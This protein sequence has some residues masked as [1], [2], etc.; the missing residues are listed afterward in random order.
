VSGF[1][2]APRDLA[3]MRAEGALSASA[4]ELLHFIAESGADRPQGLQTSVGYLIDALGFSD[5]TARR[6]LK[7]LRALDLISYENH[8]GV[9]VFTVRTT[10]R[11]ASLAGVTETVTEPVTEVVT[12][13]AGNASAGDRGSTSSKPARRTGSAAADGARVTEV[14]EGPETETE[15]ETEKDQ[16]G[17]IDFDA[18]TKA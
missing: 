10:A 16:E 2:K 14:A 15:I 5:T 9:A 7:R 8:S 17:R 4:Y 11:L 1:W 3:R 13:V 12:E 6:A 18:Y